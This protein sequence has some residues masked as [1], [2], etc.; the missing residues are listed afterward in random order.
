MKKKVVLMLTLVLLMSVAA[1]NRSNQQPVETPDN[2]G[3]TP[4]A[5]TNN[6]SEIVEIPEFSYET[7][8]DLY[9]EN[10]PD[11]KMEG[12]VNTSEVTITGIDCAIERAKIE[13]TIDWCKVRCAFDSEKG[14]WEISFYP[15]ECPGICQYVYMDNNGITLMIVSS[16][17]VIS[18]LEPWENTVYQGPL[19]CI[20]YIG[21]DGTTAVM[22]MSEAEQE[23]ILS[24]LNSGE[25]INDMSDCAHDYKFTVINASI[26][27]HSHCGTFIDMT[28]GCSM[29]LSETKKE[30]INNLFGA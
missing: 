11:V 26:R 16:Q 21:I 30:F 12:F 8:L 22:E 29:R 3:I 9:T 10:S 17:Y 14:V 28:N 19:S 24:I 25:W 2:T 27:Y 5:T 6:S 1:C 23:Q 18:T 7:V 15:E 4:D 13:C 20:T